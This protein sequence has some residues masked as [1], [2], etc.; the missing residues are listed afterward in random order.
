MLAGVQ[1]RPPRALREHLLEFIKD[2]CKAGRPI[3]PSAPFTPK[4]LRNEG[5]ACRAPNEPVSLQD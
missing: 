1:D 3:L 4:S 2:A 5:S